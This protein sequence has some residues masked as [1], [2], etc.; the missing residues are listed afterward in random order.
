MVYMLTWLGYIDGIHV[1]IYSTM[2]PMG[3]CNGVRCR[4][5]F[6]FL[7][8][9]TCLVSNFCSVLPTSAGDQQCSWPFSQ[10]QSL[11]IGEH[12]F[13]LCIYIYMCVCKCNIWYILY[14][15]MC[16]YIYIYILHIHICTIYTTDL[17]SIMQDKSPAPLPSGIYI[18]M[19]MK[20]RNGKHPQ[21]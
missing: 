5:A 20:Y 18:Y 17:S 16:W 7:T 9:Q 21:F 19:Y 8:L 3:I 15:Y 12:W 11:S 2:D 6:S 4:C 14:L 10:K 1:T 13:I